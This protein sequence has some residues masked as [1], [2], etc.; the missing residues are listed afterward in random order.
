MT[1]KYSATFC[2]P[3]KADKKLCQQFE[4]GRNY[5]AEIFCG[6]AIVH[7]SS[8]SKARLSKRQFEKHFKRSEHVPE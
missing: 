1:S 3:N 7:V 6:S 4:T 2:P 5:E 8:K